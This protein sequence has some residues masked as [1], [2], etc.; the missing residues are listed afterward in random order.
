MKINK[1]QEQLL[2]HMLGADSRYKKN[3]WGF[4][5]HFCDS[6]GS[7]DEP[8]FKD[9]V[10]KGLVKKGTR[11]EYPTYYATKAGCVAVGFKKYQLAKMKF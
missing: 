5:N 7:S 2:R 10:K 9:L 3:I 6:D 8:D 1:N 4:R 11:F